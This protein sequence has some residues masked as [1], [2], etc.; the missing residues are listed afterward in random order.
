MQENV[1]FA[2]DVVYEAGKRIRHMMQEDIKVEE[3]TSKSDLVTNVDKQ[4]EAFIVSK[5]Q[6]RYEGQNFLTEESTVDMHGSDHLWIIDPIDGTTNFIYQ[7]QHFSISV[8]YYHQGA[9][10]FGI[11][12]NVMAD[13]MFVGISGVG[14]FL[15]GE[16]LPQ[17]NQDQLLSDSVIFGDVYRP[18]FFKLSPAELKKEFI[19]HRFYG[20]GAIEI[21]EVGAGRAQAYVFPKIKTWDIAAALIILKEAGGTWYFGGEIDHLPIDKNPKVIIAA[22]NQ[23]VR[24]RLVSFL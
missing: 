2:I 20:S 3:K 24:D 1:K 18:D 14:S 13:E 5:I 17:L 15:N 11:V 23:H 4:T 8:A 7:K 22:S 6:E 21:A 9:P 10:I 16:R 19:T 12:Y